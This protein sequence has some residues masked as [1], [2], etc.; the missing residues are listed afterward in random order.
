MIQFFHVYK[1]YGQDA[2]ALTDVTMSV[3][4]GEFCFVTGPSGAGKTTLLKLI[5]AAEPV[6]DGQVIVG[7]VNV[8]RLRHSEVPGLRRKVGMVYQ[9]FRLLARRTVGQN[10]ALPLEVA[11]RPP[12]KVEERMR[13]VLALVGLPH[14]EHAFPLNL[15][16]GEQQR[17]AIARALVNDPV[18]LLAD[19]P[20]GNLDFDLTLSIMDL[21]RGANARGTTVLVATHNRE[22]LRRYQKR[23][24][25]LER[26]RMVQAG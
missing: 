4:K 16:G 17:V 13:R 24:I 20:T 9:D 11:G 6:D 22:L 14:K 26:G 25:R 10:V 2:H 7:G 8:A 18:I 21:L 3:E 23:V 12:R 19:E 5:F 1:R 15:S